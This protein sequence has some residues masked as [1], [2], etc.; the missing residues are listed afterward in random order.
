MENKTIEALEK[1]LKIKDETIKELEKQI[2]LF[3]NQPSISAP[4]YSSQPISVPFTSPVYPPGQTSPYVNNP[5]LYPPYIITSDI[6]LPPGSQQSGTI[7]S[8][9]GATSS[10][11]TID[12]NLP[13]TGRCSAYI[14]DQNDIFKITPNTNP[15]VY[16]IQKS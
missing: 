6:V 3:K 15:N 7:T 10:I 11:I 16:C 9:N 2:S 1:L 12:N 13:F 14:S 5:V 8:P 4:Y